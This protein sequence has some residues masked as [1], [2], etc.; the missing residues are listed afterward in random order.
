MFEILSILQ[1]ICVITSFMI[2]FSILDYE[3]NSN[4]HKLLLIGMVY[5]FIYNMGCV[6][7]LNC[8]GKEA[9]LF[10]F[11]IK[12]IAVCHIMILMFLF[13]IEYYNLKWS[14]PFR[15]FLIA[16]NIL[17]IAGILTCNSSQVFFKKMDFVVTKS[18]SY[19]DFEN[20][21]GAYGYYIMICFLGLIINFE[22]F[23]KYLE[24]LKDKKRKREL[25]LFMS[26]IIPFLSF[27]CYHFFY[28]ALEQK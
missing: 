12:S 4:E 2:T 18:Y 23:K 26:S 25:Y 20:G 19:L 27:F 17:I 13:I 11:Q 1:I 8:K 15:L 21:I 16:L 14:K 10:I 24:N 28:I 3:S 9:A 6:F 7:E 5:V 22:T